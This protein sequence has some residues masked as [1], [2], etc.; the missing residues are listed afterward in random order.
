[1]DSDITIISLFFQRIHVQQQVIN[2]VTI[3]SQRLKEPQA[4]MDKRK[5][6]LLDYENCLNSADSKENTQVCLTFEKLRQN[7]KISVRL[8]I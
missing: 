4:I 7:Q 6:K 3:L 8:L 2:P 5:D 1:M